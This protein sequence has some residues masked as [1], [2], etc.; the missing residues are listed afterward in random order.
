VFVTT[1]AM[2]R[3]RRRPQEAFHR[4]WQPCSALPSHDPA[5][6]NPTHDFATSALLL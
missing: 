3:R 2:R 5:R 6:I 1:Q 4:L